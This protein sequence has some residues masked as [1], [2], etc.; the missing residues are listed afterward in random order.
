MIPSA[1]EKKTFKVENGFHGEKMNG[2]GRPLTMKWKARVR[3]P[4]LKHESVAVVISALL[5]GI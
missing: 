2:L 1:D 5:Q 4:A 3:A